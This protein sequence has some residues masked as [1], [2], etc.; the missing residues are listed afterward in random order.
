MWRATKCITEMIIYLMRIYQLKIRI[1][2][3]CI[4]HGLRLNDLKV[5]NVGLTAASRHM[6]KRLHEHRARGWWWWW[7]RHSDLWCDRLLEAGHLLTFYF[8]PL[9]FFVP[10]ICFFCSDLSSQTVPLSWLWS[11]L[12]LVVAKK[13]AQ[14][15]VPFWPLAH[16]DFL[17]LFKW[18]VCHSITWNKAPP[19]KTSH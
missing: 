4:R 17:T 12:S 19:Y 5:L 18:E 8:C 7:W 15:S 2:W 6:L 3:V 9:L 11:S 14:L 10:S 1:V 16:T 13:W